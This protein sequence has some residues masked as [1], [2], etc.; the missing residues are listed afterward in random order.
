MFTIEN[1]KVIPT[2]ETLMIIVFRKIWEEDTSKDKEWALK[3][4]A[5]VEFSLSPKR[6]NPFFGYDEE[7]R[8]T[9]ILEGIGLAESELSK[10]IPEALIFYKDYIENGSP[11][12]AY[13]NSNLEAANKVRRF[14]NTVDLN[15]LNRAGMPL[16]KPKDITSA[17]QDTEKVI[18]TLYNLKAKVE[19]EIGTQGR[20]RADRDVN[21]FEE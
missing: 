17:I 16:Y 10:Y 6:T 5:Y 3:N 13:Y 19:Q 4:F 18:N 12:L 2:P 11:T 15:R 14:L 1:F 7:I 20:T 9:K 8:P 21:P